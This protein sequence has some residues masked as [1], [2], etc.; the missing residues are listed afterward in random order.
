[1]TK[2]DL[3][4]MLEIDQIKADQPSMQPF[5]EY[6]SVFC[7]QVLRTL[8]NGVSLDDN[9]NGTSKLVNIFHDTETVVFAIPLPKPITEV[10]IRRVV[11]N[12][13]Y[14]V[15][16]FGWKYDN[17]GDIVVKVKFAGSPPVNTQI[18]VVLAFLFS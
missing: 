11:D 13:Y 9:L 10:Y 15:E 8:R 16:A 2:L 3:G 18:K 6:M 7:E 12:I 5:L 1:M 4:R 14:Q 17:S